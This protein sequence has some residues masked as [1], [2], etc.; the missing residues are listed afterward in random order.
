MIFS[1]S[2]EAG[3]GYLLHSKA[4]ILS[5]KSKLLEIVKKV[6]PDVI[7]QDASLDCELTIDFSGLS[8]WSQVGFK[9]IV[10]LNPFSSVHL[11]SYKKKNI[12]FYAYIYTHTHRGQHFKLIERVPAQKVCVAR[13]LNHWSSVRRDAR[14][15]IQGRKNCVSRVPY[16]YPNI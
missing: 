7:A 8:S 3:G 9:A 12:Y 11:L 5:F 14:D 1:F 16:H 2:H 4:E 6:K 10:K 15:H 13:L